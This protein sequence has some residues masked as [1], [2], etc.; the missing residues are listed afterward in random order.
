MSGGRRI[1][2]AS[3]NAG[4]LREIGELLAPLGVELVPQGELGIRG[5]A[6]TGATFLDNA[7]LKARHA[8]AGS[9][10]PAIGDDSGL[11]VAALDGAPGVRSARYAGAAAGDAAN[12]DKL[13][14]AL[15]GVPQDRRGAAFH[16][17]AVYVDSEDDPE[18]LV[19]EGA[20]HGRILEARRG[21]G[22]FGYDPV[23]LDVAAG[24]AAAELA[25]AEKNARSHRGQALRAL[26]EALAERW[27]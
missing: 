7:L 5:A 19:A 17:V 11:A 2:L 10:L 1:V 21:E 15:R 20:W 26:R 13:L 22:G 4:K 18:P 25:P 16:C 12:I 3:G 6:E 24:R 9:G 14:A 27:Q 8:A 23:F